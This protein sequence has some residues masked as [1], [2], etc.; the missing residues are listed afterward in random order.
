MGTAIKHPMPGRVKPSFVI[1]D[2]RAL[3]RSGLS[4]RVPG[5]QKLQRL[6]PVWHKMLYSCT[7][8]APLGVKGL[9]EYEHEHERR[10]NL[11]EHHRETDRDKASC[12]RSSTGGRCPDTV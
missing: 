12:Y 9:N 11:T 3:W 6:N 7:H 5:C 2:I 10:P 8:V 4:V 1:F